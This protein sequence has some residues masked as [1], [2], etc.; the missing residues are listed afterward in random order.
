M[1]SS[2][3]VA[4]LVK[5]AQAW[6]ETVEEPLG[7]GDA[8]H[9]IHFLENERTRKW[10]RVQ[11]VPNELRARVLAATTVPCSPVDRTWAIKDGDGTCR[12]C[13]ALWLGILLSSEPEH[14]PVPFDVDAWLAQL[15]EG[16]DR[17]AMEQEYW[18]AVWDAT[19]RYSPPGYLPTRGSVFK[20]LGVEY[21]EVQA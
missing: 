18:A 2:N 15:P 21:D 11:V 5:A 10:T 4:R 12:H 8:G 9:G 3:D 17:D 6:P 20:T 19:G 1:S 13:G 16:I 7:F 14:N